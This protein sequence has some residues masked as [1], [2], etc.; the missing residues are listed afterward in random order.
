MTPREE[1][2]EA[3]AA[4]IAVLQAERDRLANEHLFVED[5]IKSLEFTVRQA[6]VALE[7]QFPPVI[8]LDSIA[9]EVAAQRIAGLSVIAS[10]EFLQ[11][12]SERIAKGPRPRQAS[13]QWS[14]LNR[15]ETAARIEQIGVRLG[16]LQIELAKQQARQRAADAQAELERLERG[17]P[18]LVA[19]DGTPTQTAVGDDEDDLGAKSPS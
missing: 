9:P 7:E 6:R 1:D 8:W 3:P 14:T 15:A 19:A 13:V 5:A 12:E 17:E 4:E 10:E 2:T 16:E 11:R 18:A